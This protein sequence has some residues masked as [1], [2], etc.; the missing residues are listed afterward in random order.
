MIALF[1]QEELESKRFSKDL[2][3]VINDLNIPPEIISKY[4]L[5]NIADNNVRKLIL[6]LYRGYGDNKEIFNNFPTNIEWY[7]CKLDKLDI[8]KIKYID[9]DYWIELTNGTR[10]II[11]SKKNILM[12]K[13]TFGV[14]NQPFI[15]GADYLKKGGIFPPIIILSSK[16]SNNEMIVLEGH[17]RLASISLAFDYINTIDALI[18]F[19][20]K[21]E[22]YN[23]NKY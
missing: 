15:D 2:L 6:K 13:E 9:Y 1:L 18:G 3:R 5:S 8:S 19:V 20:K 7:W 16:E 22:L 21:E 11:D 12:G 4:D 23:W 17:S 10:Y 14:S